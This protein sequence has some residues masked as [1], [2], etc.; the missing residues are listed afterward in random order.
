VEVA[1][2]VGR[3]HQ[4]R[5]LVRLG[6]R[7]LATILAQFRLDERK[8]E[9][10]VD[11]ILGDAGIP[12]LASNKPYSLSFQPCSLARARNAILCALEPVK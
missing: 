6:D 11:F 1:A 5:Q 3:G 10:R 7:N 2:N 8:S 12:P 4:T 9:L